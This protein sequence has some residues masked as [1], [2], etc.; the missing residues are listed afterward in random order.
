MMDK[1]TDGRIKLVELF[2]MAKQRKFFIGGCSI[3]ENSS[4]Y[5]CYTCRKSFSKDLKRSIQANDD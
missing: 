4:D 2:E 1:L 3:D 5:H